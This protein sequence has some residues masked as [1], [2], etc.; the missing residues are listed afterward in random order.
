MGYYDNIPGP[1]EYR[2]TVDAEAT[3]LPKHDAV[4]RKLGAAAERIFSKGANAAASS[5]VTFVVVGLIL[6]MMAGFAVKKNA[7]LTGALGAAGGFAAAK[8]FE[9]RSKKGKA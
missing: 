1:T 9:S 4:D 3:E 6:G 2:F 8:Y 5:T 7:L